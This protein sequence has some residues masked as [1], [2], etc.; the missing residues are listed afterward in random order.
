MYKVSARGARSRKNTRNSAV[1]AGRSANKKKTKKKKKKHKK[2]KRCRLYSVTQW[3]LTLVDISSSCRRAPASRNIL[4]TGLR[5][6]D[7][8]YREAANENISRPP[9]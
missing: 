9:P 8:G 5:R 4:D 3:R 1:S 6:S 2:N 7:V